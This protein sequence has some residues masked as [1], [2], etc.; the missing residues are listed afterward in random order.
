MKI[1]SSI[2]IVSVL[3]FFS[4]TA[5]ASQDRL[6]ITNV[7]LIDGTGRPPRKDINVFIDGDRISDIRRGSINRSE[8]KNAKVIDGRGKYLIPGLM[9][10][11]VHLVGS[12]KVSKA[13]IRETTV[14]R[15]RGLRALNGYLYSG[16]TTI[17][18]SG[19]IPEFIM[20]LRDDERAGRISSPRIFATGGIV[21][22]PGS[23]G[24]GAGA[25][26]VDDWPEAM[27]ALDEHIARQ[28]D[29]LKLT[30]EERGWG[31]RPMIPLLPVELMEK[32]IA[33]YNDRGIRATAHAASELR[34]RQAIFAGIDSL[35]HPVITGPI[36][37]SF[38]R[39][40]GVK[41]IPMA[42]TLTIGENYSRLAEH[43][44]Y[45]DQPLYQAVLTEDEINDLKTKTSDEYKK[46]T[47]TWWMKLMTPIA[48]DNLRQIHEAGGVLALG[49][50]KSSGP[51]AHREM[52]LLVAAGIAP[53]DVIRIATLHGAKFLGLEDE[54]GSIAPGKLADMVLLDADPLADINNA[55]KI[56]MVI[57]NGVL[58]ERSRL[59]VKAGP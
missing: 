1:A 50:D 51:A 45:L 6:V 44:E 16:I 29:M 10:V 47:W 32:I 2:I 4:Y 12:I 8:K 20:G 38:A 25:T 42:T 28:P 36:S 18:D 56:N 5:V 59:R 24:S 9:D 11:H 37:E 34:A 21:T 26:L 13:G 48:Q 15:D 40:M 55:K 33:Y 17:Y 3:C 54:L 49:T 41:K 30:L 31:A 14:D 43:P 19:N 35:S 23:H 27:A 53:L 58:V 7:T 57:K 52:E 46:R 39:L 22:Y